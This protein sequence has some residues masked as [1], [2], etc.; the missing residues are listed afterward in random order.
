MT[1]NII[2]MHVHYF[3]PAVFRAIW[4]FFESQSNGLWKIRYKLSQDK[5]LETLRNEGVARCTTLVYA[6]KPDMADALNDFIRREAERR[7]VLLP[8]GTIFAGDGRVGER[9]RRLFEE[10]GFFGIKLHPFVSGEEI[11][12]ERFWPAYEI[13]AER[14]RVLV[15]HP[16]SGPVYAATDGA[17]RLRRVLER[18]PNLRVVVAHCG[19]FEYG[20][21]PELALDFPHVYFDTAMNCVHTEVFH[22]NCP[23]R[24]FFLRNH[25][26]IL[27]GSDFPNVPYPY[28][29]QKAAITRLG[30]GPAIEDSIFFG[31]ARR[32]LE[33]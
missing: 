1:A 22:N 27:F 9:A 33:I 8:F 7:P 20:D 3:P 29:D 24:E 5:H 23:G 32:L 13:M 2:D 11:D 25:D 28:G 19:A 17:G 6:H 26:R 15:C 14:R 4:R 12:D 30:L 18:F 10:F 16:G 21:Y 31:N